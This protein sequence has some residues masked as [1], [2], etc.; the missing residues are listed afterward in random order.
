MA[1][2][3]AVGM[4]VSGIVAFGVLALIVLLVKDFF[5]YQKGARNIRDY[6]YTGPDRSQWFWT[7]Y[8][9]KLWLR[10]F[11]KGS[12]WFSET[13]DPED[14]NYDLEIYENGKIVRKPTRYPG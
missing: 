4:I 12:G 6:A 1:F 2:F 14:D 9:M 13:A 7:K 10:S 3:T 11:R 5:G 8:G